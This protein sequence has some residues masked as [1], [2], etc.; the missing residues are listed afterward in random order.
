MEEKPTVQM[1]GYTPD[2]QDSSSEGAY[3]PTVPAEDMRRQQQG[4]GP[5][6]APP[7]RPVPQPPV[8][9]FTPPPA[10][11]APAGA[12]RVMGRPI[13]PPPLA[14]LA[15]VEGPGAPRG[16]VFT[17]QRETVVGRTTGQIVLAGDAYISGQHVK[18]RVEPSEEDPEKEVWV[19][20]DLA[21]ANGTFAGS[22]ENYR[23]NQVYRYELH[24][25]DF[26]LLG[27]TT[28]VFKQV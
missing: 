10:Q 18:I 16:Q 19:L 21:S 12:T 7:P 13:P 4:W 27:E 5:V 23:E 17:L 6:T 14:F 11:P 8:S 24:D 26:I 28:L 15:V 25:G 9:P 1:G 2:D 3:S 22:R 20:Y